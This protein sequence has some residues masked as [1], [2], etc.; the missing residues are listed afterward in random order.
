MSDRDNRVNTKVRT[1]VREDYVYGSAA[2]KREIMPASTAKVAKKLALRK[3]ARKKRRVSFFEVVAL[4]GGLVVLSCAVYTAALNTKVKISQR[5]ITK[6][7]AALENLKAKNNE[8]ENRI[9]SY[10]DLNNV[11]EVATK[12]LGMVYAKK[13]QVIEY[14]K[15]ESEYVKQDEDIPKN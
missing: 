8:L 4:V 2:Q 7:E 10:I 11:Y 12:R 1:K 5:E 13:N 6:Q 9:N 15:T 14:K 3:K